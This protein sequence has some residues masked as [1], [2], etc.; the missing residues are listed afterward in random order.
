MDRQP[1]LVCQVGEF[2]KSYHELRAG[3]AVVGTLPLHP[4]ERFKLLDLADRGVTLFPPALAQFLNSSKI[5]QAEILREFMIPGTFVAYRLAD[6]TDR[7]PEFSEFHP[8]PVVSKR[9]RAHLGLGVGRWDSL[10]ALYSLAGL[11][12]LPYPLVVQP[13]IEGARDFRVVIIGD[14]AEAYERV[15]PHG[16]RKNLFH[17]GFSRAAATDPSLLDFCH[18]VMA[19]GKFPYA[20]LDLLVSPAGEPYLSEINLQGGLTGARLKQAEFRQKV[21]A[22]TQEFCQAWENSSKNQP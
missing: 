18:R 17:G 6:L 8:G 2:R 15:N 7:L 21:A 11:Q 4:G 10:E 1:L 20:I 9:D 5:T 14:Y 22:L 3:D 19:R 13:F 12:S 16:F